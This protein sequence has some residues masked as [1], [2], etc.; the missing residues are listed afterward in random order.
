MN[1]HYACCIFHFQHDIVEM[2]K[3]NAQLRWSLNEAVNVWT[4]DRD[5]TGN[6]QTLL[7]QL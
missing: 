7:I 1:I 4:N 3:E 5:L 2:K 6:P